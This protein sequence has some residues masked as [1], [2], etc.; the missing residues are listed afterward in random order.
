VQFFKPLAKIKTGRPEKHSKL[1]PWEGPTAP[2]LGRGRKTAVDG[3]HVSWRVPLMSC[4]GNCHGNV[5]GGSVPKEMISHLEK[6]IEDFSQRN[7]PLAW[8]EMGRICYCSLF[9]CFQTGIFQ[10]RMQVCSFKIFWKC[11]PW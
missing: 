8:A 1:L 10:V 6:A 9:V 11:A 7:Q 2:T 4:M 3:T 5:G